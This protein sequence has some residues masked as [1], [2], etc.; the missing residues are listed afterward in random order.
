MILTENIK[1]LTHEQ[2]KTILSFVMDLNTEDA[3][4]ARMIFPLSTELANKIGLDIT[5]P[6]IVKVAMGIGGYRQNQLEIKTFLEQCDYLP[7]AEIAAYGRFVEIMERVEVEDWRDFYDNYCDVDDYMCEIEQKEN[8][9]DEEFQERYDR[10]YKNTV[11]AVS[12]IDCLNDF[13]GHTGDNGQIGINR[14]GNFVAYDYGYTTSR[15]TDEQVSDVSD[16]V[17]DKDDRNSY[18]QGLFDLLD[19]E[20]SL[21]ENYEKKFLYDENGDG[22]YTRYEIQY[23]KKAPEWMEK[24][25]DCGCFNWYRT[26]E[27]AKRDVDENAKTEGEWKFLAYCLEEKTYDCLNH[28]CICTEVLEANIP[29][30]YRE[31]WEKEH[32]D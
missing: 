20:E 16:T 3:G 31:I 7:L 13:F 4:C 10:I 25:Y 9:S 14:L 30:E 11:N 24:E 29:D 27:E 32:E 28:D 19:K 17:Y 12:T 8:E 23:V 26:Y 2:E 5:F 15:T 6:C 22:T 1:V 18:I 21:L